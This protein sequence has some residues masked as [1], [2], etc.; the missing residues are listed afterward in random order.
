MK[1][2]HSQAM[3]NVLQ[4]II[5]MAKDAI[6]NQISSKSPNKHGLEDTDAELDESDLEKLKSVSSEE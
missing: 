4:E 5:D 2:I 1:D 3:G 6:G